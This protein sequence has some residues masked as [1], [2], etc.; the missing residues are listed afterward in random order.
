MVLQSDENMRKCC[1]CKQS[2]GDNHFTKGDPRC[3]ECR[4]KKN[5]KSRYGISL[6]EYKMILYHQNSGC[7]ICGVVIPMYD[8]HVDHCHTTNK[9]RGLLCNKCNRG[10]G[11]LGDSIE[12]L[13]AAIMYLRKGS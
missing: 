10:L 1:S 13:E 2:P 9:V 7:A 4:R 3:K 12:R 11:F 5:L 6:E 8:Y